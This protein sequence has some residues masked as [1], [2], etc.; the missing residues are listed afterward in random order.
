M[1]FDRDGKFGPCVNALFQGYG[2]LAELAPGKSFAWGDF[3]LLLKRLEELPASAQDIMHTH[4]SFL[5]ILL[6]LYLNAGPTEVLFEGRAQNPLHGWWS[7]SEP[8]TDTCTSWCPT[9]RLLTSS[10][11]S[12]SV[13]WA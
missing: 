1:D 6:S 10:R 8:T 7:C 5:R 11:P 9:A 4:Y 12:S 2:K 3:E 13:S